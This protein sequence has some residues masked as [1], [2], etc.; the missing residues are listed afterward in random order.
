MISNFMDK[1]HNTIYQSEQTDFLVSQIIELASRNQKVGNLTRN[2]FNILLLYSSKYGSPEQSKELFSIMKGIYKLSPNTESFNCLMAQKGEDI[3]VDIISPCVDELIR[4]NVSP[5]NLTWFLL[6]DRI[7]EEPLKESLLDE[8]KELKI[9]NTEFAPYLLKWKSKKSSLDEA[10]QFTQSVTGST[11]HS[12]CPV[13]FTDSILALPFNSKVRP[14]TS[15]HDYIYQAKNEV[16]FTDED[17]NLK[18]KKQDVNDALSVVLSPDNIYSDITSNIKLQSF[19]NEII[20]S[21]PNLLTQMSWQRIIHYFLQ[22]Y[23]FREAFLILHE[24][25]EEFLMTTFLFNSILFHCLTSRSPLGKELAA[26]FFHH[27]KD[28]FHLSTDYS[29]WKILLQ[30]YQDAKLEQKLQLSNIIMKLKLKNNPMILFIMK[31]KYEELSDPI[32]VLNWV[33]SN[34]SSE[35][36]EISKMAFLVEILLKHDLYNEAV[37][38]INKNNSLYYLDVMKSLLQ[39][40]VNRNEVVKAATLLELFAK[41]T[42]KTG[43]V[44]R[45]QFAEFQSVLDFDLGKCQ[46]EADSEK[47][48]LISQFNQLNDRWVIQKFLQIAS[49]APKVDLEEESHF[50]NTGYSKQ[51]LTVDLSQTSVNPNNVLKKVFGSSVRFNHDDTDAITRYILQLDYNVISP[52]S[53]TKIFDFLAYRFD[54]NTMFIVL[55][56]MQLS[57]KDPRLIDLNLLLKCAYSKKKQE[58]DRAMVVLQ[59]FE[60]YDKQPNRTTWFV[61]FQALN[62]NESRSMMLNAMLKLKISLNE[63]LVPVATAK[64]DELKNTESVISWLHEHQKL[65]GVKS[66][67]FT[68]GLVTNAIFSCYLLEK[69]PLDAMKFLLFNSAKGEISRHKI[70]LFIDYYL[71]RNDLMGAY[72]SLVFLKEAYNSYSFYERGYAKLAEFASTRPGAQTLLNTVTGVVEPTSKVKQ[73]LCRVYEPRLK[74]I[75]AAIQSK[76]IYFESDSLA[77][78]FE[79]MKMTP[80]CELHD[81]IFKRNMFSKLN[82]IT[83]LKVDDWDGRD[84]N[85]L[86]DE[87]ALSEKCYSSDTTSVIV[88][89]LMRCDLEKLGMKSKYTILEFFVFSGY[90]VAFRRLLKH[91][92]KDGLKM[93]PDVMNLFIYESIKKHDYNAVFNHLSGFKKLSITANRS[94]WEIIR[95][96]LGNSF[97]GKRLGELLRRKLR[98][99]QKAGNAKPKSIIH[100]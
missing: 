71:D 80:D 12:S 15:F 57:K 2:S 86:I 89:H 46:A 18:A 24:H 97:N 64:F 99:Q 54:T 67:V 11:I 30:I 10:I 50:L 1:K 6:F 76:D 63:I 69:R 41:K 25:G 100:W 29:T 78:R 62:E 21:T 28:L 32:S 19:I 48:V 88:N 72:L 66:E 31:T 17:F 52:S 8:M 55:E 43:N 85:D 98:E 77:Q 47:H 5:N 56:H 93:T 13:S 49:T 16:K 34:L 95:S 3:Q 73:Y 26:S 7:T 91:F 51:P 14:R 96:S 83:E 9:L 59:M 38:L 84:I 44:V 4:L 58:I 74:Q 79:Q 23:K 94:T 39:F 75:R 68:R 82:T 70:D 92:V 20:K 35:S 27:K 90:F 45:S 42:R 37:Q 87:L 65:T 40:H 33:N 53:Y 81:R 36:V 61:I 60:K 22:K